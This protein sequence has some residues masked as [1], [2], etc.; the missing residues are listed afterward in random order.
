MLDVPSG[1]DDDIALARWRQR[2]NLMRELLRWPLTP[3]VVLRHAAGASLAFEAP[4][5]QLLTAT[6]VN[7]WA[8][9]GAISSP[10]L[11]PSPLGPA[12]A[13]HDAALA[14]PL[15]LKLAA[16]EAPAHFAD[17]H[18]TALGRDVPLT[19]D[20]EC[21]TLGGGDH[22]MSWPVGELPAPGRVPWRQV[23]AIPT[24]LVA[25]SNGKTTT[26]RLV[27]AMCEAQGL[28]TGHS[29]TDGVRVGREWLE[30]GDWS[31]PA[32][33]R[34]VLRDDRVQAAVLETAR[35]GI[36]RRGLAVTHARA[37]IV[38]NVQ[39]DHLGEY[40][41]A[42]GAQIAD[43][44]LVVAKGLA[45]DGTLVLNA[46]DALLVPRGTAREGRTAWFSLDEQS[47]V[48]QGARA[49]GAPVAFL[50]ANDV[51]L[52]VAGSAT[53]VLGRGSALPI[54]AGGQ[55]RYNIANALGA[56]LVAYAMGVP[57]VTIAAV[58]ARF[59]TNRD[60]NPGRLMR[61]TIGG[62]RVLLD[63]A[64]NPDGLAG[65][66]AVARA[67][68]AP[69]GRMFVLLGQAGNREDDAIRAL[70]RVVAAERPAGV[71]LKDLEGFLRGRAP[72]EVPAILSDELLTHGMPAGA[73]ETILPELDAARAVVAKGRAGDVVVLPVHGHAA[74]EAAIAWL[75]AEE[76]RT[77]PR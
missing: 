58:L 24:A 54:S 53:Y 18:A 60:D 77:A 5:D 68:L 29:C 67:E 3:L 2:A 10:A 73:I 66:F 51:M 1:S 40:G 27:A 11:F 70:A 28:L 47:P 32:G 21:V 35:G 34:R 46:D 7:E 62:A 64:H 36:L 50:A 17:L 16:S 52:L 38:T 69:G 20:D 8:W 30:T 45:R 33:A 63:Y 26:V 15:F 14:M 43:V 4:I 56:S 72:G 25:G 59:G 71:V 55:A 48:I 74:R 41:I 37:A 61:W 76:R 6:E 42:T 49:A 31:G 39:L 75:D 19:F 9:L 12:E 13:P 57:P 65:L 23:A 22:A 44:K